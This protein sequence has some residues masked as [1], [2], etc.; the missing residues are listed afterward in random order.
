[1]TAVNRGGVVLSAVK[2]GVS[3]DAVASVAD[4]ME[5]CVCVCVCSSTKNTHGRLD[6]AAR[7]VSKQLFSYIDSVLQVQNPYKL[8]TNGI[9][10]GAA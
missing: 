9:F 4:M 3:G 1:V 10:R 8:N 2:T 7:L 6:Q 5:V